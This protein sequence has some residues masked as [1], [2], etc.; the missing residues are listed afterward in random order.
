MSHLGQPLR[1]ADEALQLPRGCADRLGSPAHHVA[2]VEVPLDEG[3]DG[4]LAYLQS[5]AEFGAFSKSEWHLDGK[6]WG[7]GGGNFFFGRVILAVHTH[8]KKNTKPPVK[9]A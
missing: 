7:R 5:R 4:R 3:P 8:Q 2:H 6:R 1:Q 9:W